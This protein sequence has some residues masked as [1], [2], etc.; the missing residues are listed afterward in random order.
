MPEEK[1][2]WIDGEF[3]EWKNA[4]IHV[5]SHS[6]HYG[7]SVFEG[8]RFYET[9]RGPAIFRLKDHVKRLAHSISAFGAKPPYNEEE[10][11]QA[12]KET[13]K[14]NKIPSGY[15]RPLLFFGEKIGLI[16]TGL[17]LHLAI[18]VVP[19]PSYLGEDPIKVKISSIMR[20]HPKTTD[21]TAKIGG[22]YA[23][24]ILASMEV[25]NQGYDEALL[26]DEKGNV[27]EGPGENFFIV[28]NKTLITPP[29]GSI[30]PG[31]TRASVIQIAEDQNIEIA[32]TPLTI[33]ETK[34]ADEAFFTGTAAEVTPIKSIDDAPIG[35]GSIGE[36]TS[37][38]KKTFDEVVA[39]KNEKYIEWLDFVE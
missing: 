22:H 9:E 21:M 8:I 20:I 16:N 14:K 23:N 30:L 36:I 32:Q 33:E 34:K 27:A 4:K 25:K 11:I 1:Y 17:D 28:K 37:K 26:L 6:L 2:V 24:S 29:I 39:G 13:V 38:I 35:D 5:M 18:I 31:I 15:I 7:D 19:F 12:I 3:L 10:I